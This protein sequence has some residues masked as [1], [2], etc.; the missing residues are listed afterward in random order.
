[1]ISREHGKPC[2]VTTRSMN[3][4]AKRNENIQTRGSGARAG[5]SKRAI[6]SGPCSVRTAK[7][8]RNGS[9]R[10]VVRTSLDI[11]TAAQRRTRLS[12]FCLAS[13]SELAHREIVTLITAA[14]PTVCGGNSRWGTPRSAKCFIVT[15]KRTP[16]DE[17]RRLTILAWTA[18]GAARKGE[19]AG[20]RARAA[21]RPEEGGRAPNRHHP[22]L[23][24]IWIENA[25][26]TQLGLPLI[27]VTPVDRPAANRTRAL[28]ELRKRRA[29]CTSAIEATGYSSA[30]EH[31][32][33]KLRS[34]M[35]GLRRTGQSLRAEAG[36]TARRPFSED[37]WFI[38][39][40]RVEVD[41]E[42]V[43]ILGRDSDLINV[44]GQKVYPAEVESVILEMDSVSG[45]E[46]FGTPNP[47]TGNMVCARVVLKAPEDPREFTHK[48]KTFCGA[49]LENFKVPVRVFVEGKEMHSPR[50]KK[51]RSKDTPR[52]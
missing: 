11:W 23:S 51:M 42:Y 22:G 27:S 14:V 39:G 33:H 32:S 2:A 46:V 29:A 36:T 31:W 26:R 40:D 7:W 48:L 44:G 37:G 20:A 38:T 1:M 16:K 3:G 28:R 17:T 24:K 41:G 5:V 4:T 8:Q 9:R 50:F 13:F 30:A 21:S 25:R 18:S 15:M 35:K 45:V 49:R 47:I 12:D 52:R 43:R 34:S 6:L 10:G 19:S